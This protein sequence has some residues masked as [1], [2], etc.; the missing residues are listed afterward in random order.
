MVQPNKYGFPG[1]KPKSRN[2]MKH[3]FMTGD[4]VKIVGG[5]HTGKM[6]RLTARVGGADVRD[7]HKKLFSTTYKNLKLIQRNNGW[8]LYKKPV[9]L[10]FLK[11]ISETH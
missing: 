8:Q 4:I 9:N 1:K 2:K 11:E 6:G 7:E 3:G 10:E 5:K